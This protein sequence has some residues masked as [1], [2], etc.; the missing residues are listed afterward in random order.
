[1]HRNFLARS[2]GNDQIAWVFIIATMICYQMDA[3]QGH[4]ATSQHC[5]AQSIK[6]FLA[7]QGNFYFFASSSSPFYAQPPE[8][9]L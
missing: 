5:L 3:W 9:G 1:M 6:K 7:T 8:I 2:Q 4:G